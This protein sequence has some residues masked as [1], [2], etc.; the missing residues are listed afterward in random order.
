MAAAEAERSAPASG[1][2]N[3]GG[4]APAPAPVPLQEIQVAIP[5][6]VLTCASSL[7]ACPCSLADDNRAC[8]SGLPEVFQRRSP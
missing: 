3:G 6:S 4:A 1:N 2:A 8:F 7:Y 5:A